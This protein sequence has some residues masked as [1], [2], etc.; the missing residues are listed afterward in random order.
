MK[1]YRQT[2]EEDYRAVQE[3]KPNG[4]TRTRYVYIG[5]WH[6][7][8]AT[9]ERLRV[10]KRV[11][12]LASGL[13]TAIFLLGA[14]IRSPLTWNRWV[15]LLTGLALAAVLLA[16]VGVAQF[17]AAK[18]RLSRQYFGDINAK[19]MLAPLAHAILLAGAAVASV[20]ALAGMRAA[21]TD[22]LVPVCFLASALAAA[23]TF[24]L[25]RSLPRKVMENEAA[26]QAPVS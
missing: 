22:A 7:W 24:R 26:T 17:C 18:P 1:T 13:G 9:Q 15:A 12:A 25:Y 20:I 11:M 14:L 3:P 2:F 8:D 6:V 10:V 23:G 4:G 16:V 21:W 5:N 19:L